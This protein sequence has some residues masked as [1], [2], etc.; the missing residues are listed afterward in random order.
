MTNLTFATLS[1]NANNTPVSEQ[2]DDIYFSTQDGLAESYYV[3]QEGNQLW[4][5]WQQHSRSHFVIAE[6]GFGTGLNFL[7][8]VDSFRQ[9]RQTFPTSTLK[10]LFFISFEKYPI[11][12]SQL[13]TIHS[14]YP[15]FSDL[16]AQLVTYWQPR[17]IGCERYHFSDVTLDVWFG[18]IAENLVQLGDYHNQQIDCWFLDGFSPE[19]NPDM[20][21][22]HL[23]QQMFRLTRNGGSF[24]TFTAA[25]A[26]RRGLQAV[27]FEVKK[28][29]GFGKKREMLWGEKP[30]DSLPAILRFPYLFQKNQTDTEDIAIVGGGVASLFVALSLVERG[31]NVTLYCK[32]REL[33]TNASGNL[34]GAIYPQ[35]SDDDERNVRFYLHSFD[36]ACQ[37]LKQLA[38]YIEFEHEFSGVG[39]Y[40]YNEK[41]EKKLR[42]LCEKE[43]DIIAW[44]DAREFSQ[45]LG[46]NVPNGGA[47]I[48]QGGWLSPKQLV[49][50]GFLF[51]QK[52]GL[53]IVFDH[54][55][56]DLTWNGTHW[57]WQHGDNLYQHQTVILAN[58]HLLK[59]FK[60]T[61]GI[62][63][64]PVRGQVS[65][66]PTTPQLAQLKAVL[67]Y[68][69]YLTPKSASYYH[70]VGASHI[71][72][73]QESDFSLEEHQQNLAKLLQNL[74]ACHWLYDIDFSENRGKVGIR[75]AFRD[76]MPMVGAV[77]NYSAQLTQYPNLYN[78]LRRQD[79]LDVAI[80]QPNLYLI[81]GLGSRGLTT[82]P[83]LGELLAS[84][85]NQ[86]PLPL[87]EDIWQV[88][89]TNRSWMRNWVRGR[90]P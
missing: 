67:C 50:N 43:W 25:S 77:P 53:N 47:F 81:A 44:Q 68:D 42:K 9:F 85:I 21:N 10:R 65:H 64:Y 61:E 5:K 83:L 51:L 87:S 75:S 24:A 30:Q 20:W 26:V 84:Q 46:M 34:Q 15:Q 33:A 37:R 38:Q 88:I 45:S 41:T 6:T 73:N 72:D 63:L 3:F 40:A 59:Q 36:Y 11:T 2:F 28:R 7:A 70:C 54:F 71:R 14:N 78:Q 17:Q 29:K 4:Q 23:Y 31:K 90:Q 49:Q 12:S 89:T 69:G 22:E 55:V 86:E 57:Q 76:R 13:S 79:L 39:L 82:A 16:S 32:D 19:K 56:D 8:V 74:G 52:L 27:G 62:P 66:I 1:F 18:D 60:Q 80:C 35:L 48:R 58:G